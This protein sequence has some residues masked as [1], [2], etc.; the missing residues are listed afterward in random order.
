M[1]DVI[2][3]SRPTFDPKSIEKMHAYK[4]LSRA[5]GEERTAIR[6]T[7]PGGTEASRAGKM[8]SRRMN[9]GGEPKFVQVMAGHKEFL[10]KSLR[11]HPREELVSQAKPSH[12]T[13][14]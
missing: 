6:Y 3:Y 4:D 7:E 2:Q 5:I 13:A 10:S 11:Y 14:F 9:K 1:Y 8:T 12:S